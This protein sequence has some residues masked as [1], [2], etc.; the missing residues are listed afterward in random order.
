MKLLICTQALD[1]NDPILG[2]FH[3]WVEEFAKHFEHVHVI[4]LREGAHA[5]PSNVSVYSLGKERGSIRFVRWLRALRYIVVLRKEYDAV[6]VH[7]NP[8][9][10][11]LGGWFWTLMHKKTAL[12]YMHKTVDFKLRAAVMFVQ[13]IFTGSPE[14]FRLKTPKVE[15]MGHGI[16]TLFFSPDPRGVRGEAVLSV[17]RLSA[18][19]RHDLI[20]RAAHQAHKKL[21]IVGDGPERTALEALAQKLGAS[22]HFLGGHTQEQLL[23]EYRKAGVF[24][25]TSETGSMDKVVL[26]ALATDTPVITTSEVFKNFPV[27]VVDAT[28]ESLTQALMHVEEK[29]D[30][31]SAVE[32]YHSLPRL[33]ARISAWY[34]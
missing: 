24:I 7:M 26:E 10:V 8:E 2:F 3:A 18:S 14:S 1:K 32:K 33:I 28:Q 12:W 9:Y 25:H 23:H 4:C 17:G 11:L 19:K 21:F 15:V 16:D 20:I 30:R 31:V 27:Q 34:A 13:K 22:V 5:L 6:F 29:T